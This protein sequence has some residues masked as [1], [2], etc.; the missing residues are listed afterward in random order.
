MGVSLALIFFLLTFYYIF[1]IFK[2]G[3]HPYSLWVSN[4]FLSELI[5][6]FRLLRLFRL[7]FILELLSFKHQSI[8]SSISAREH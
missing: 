6:S 1:F 8:G 7:S 2:S 4:K 5:V 3:Q